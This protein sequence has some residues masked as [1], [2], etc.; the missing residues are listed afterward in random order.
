VTTIL[1]KDKKL[2]ADPLTA[3]GLSTPFQL[4][5]P[6]SQAVTTQ[7]SFVEAAIF[8]PATNTISV[9]HP[10][11]VNAGTTPGA[12]I[13]VPTIPANAVIGL[14][15]GFNGTLTLISHF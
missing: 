2:P 5:A 10:L 8:D 9:Y 3:T 1:I 7:Q 11:I 13:V 12:P 6:C 4:L 14:W 15:F